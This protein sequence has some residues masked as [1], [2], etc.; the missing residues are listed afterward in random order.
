[1]NITIFEINA[2]MNI[3]IKSNNYT[4]EYVD[5]IAQYTNSMIRRRL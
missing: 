4:D 5:K 2:N 3:L 1:M